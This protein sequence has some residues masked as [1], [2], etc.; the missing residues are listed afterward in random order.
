M[1]E[2]QEQVLCN[3]VSE[4]IKFTWDILYGTVGGVRTQVDEL[5][6]RALG[7]ELSLLIESNQEC[8]PEST[9][10][11]AHEVVE[12]V[13]DILVSRR[14]FRIHRPLTFN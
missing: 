7:K 11:L 2:N 5:R 6:A 12:A 14:P 13:D 4:L 3:A 10:F 1:D 8:L 9:L